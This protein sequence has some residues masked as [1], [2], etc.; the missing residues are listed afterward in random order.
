MTVLWM[1]ER[2][3]KKLF[4]KNL[5]EKQIYNLDIFPFIDESYFC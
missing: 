1:A 2:F 3:R 4:A 5:L